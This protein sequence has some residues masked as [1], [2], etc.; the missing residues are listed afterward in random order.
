[1]FQNRGTGF[2]PTK[3]KTDDLNLRTDELEVFKILVAFSAYHAKVKQ[4]M[5]DLI[6][7]FNSLLF[8][9]FSIMKRTREESNE[10][11]NERE[12]KRAK[13]TYETIENVP[14][15]LLIV[16][17]GRMSAKQG[18]NLLK[19]IFMHIFIY[20]CWIVIHLLI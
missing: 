15:E 16:I 19:K 17:L 11:D 3:K 4:F 10:Q 14:D 9:I 8:F 5:S 18:G 13:M 12:L 1:M 6:K 2:E 20:F 7:N